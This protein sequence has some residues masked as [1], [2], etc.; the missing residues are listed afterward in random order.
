MGSWTSLAGRGWAGVGVGW[1]E[2]MWQTS[3]GGQ[4]GSERR[5]EPSLGD[6]EGAAALAVGA[7]G[8]FGLLA[9]RGPRRGLP[10]PL[11]RTP[12]IPLGHP[13]CG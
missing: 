4:G 6:R 1:A 11:P 10:R 8:S 2:R 12:L 9:K 5:A 7:E 13:P 3:L